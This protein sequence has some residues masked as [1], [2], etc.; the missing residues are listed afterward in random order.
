M[1]QEPKTETGP[2]SV[3][4]VPPDQQINVEVAATEKTE[5]IIKHRVSHVSGTP[6]DHGRAIIMHVDLG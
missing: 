3:Q 1:G 5:Q 6:G 4:M 2:V